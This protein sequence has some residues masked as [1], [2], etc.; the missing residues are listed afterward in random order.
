M[1]YI[2]LFHIAQLNMTRFHVK[3][4]NSSYSG[5]NPIALINMHDSCGSAAPNQY[6]Y[7]QLISCR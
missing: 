1:K 3:P 5:G 7:Y 2:H 6:A 4:H